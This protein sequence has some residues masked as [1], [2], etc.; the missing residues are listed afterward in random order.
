MWDTGGSDRRQ[1]ANMGHSAAQV[2]YTDGEK[3]STGMIRAALDHLNVT[4]TH[5]D[6]AEDC[7]DSLRTQEC[8]LLISNAKRPAVEGV[9][10]L[11]GARRITPSVPVVL[12]VDH[13]DIQAA[14]RAMKGGAVDCLERP[15]EKAHL[16]SAIKSALQESVQNS[17]PQENPLSKAEEQVLGLIL[18]GHTTTETARAL[19]RSPRT[20][21]VHRSHIMRKLGTSNMVELVRTAASMGL[22]DA[23]APPSPAL[24]SPPDQAEDRP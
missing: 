18:Q 13:G 7:L 11:L 21:E 15:P 8:H 10:L 17:L 1:E 20:I 4:I 5:F 14:V 9:E 3:T 19:H 2:F 24:V 16:V 23:S 22:L 6:D 12:L